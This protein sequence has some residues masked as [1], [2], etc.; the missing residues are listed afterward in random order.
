[1]SDKSDKQIERLEHL[2]EQ[3]IK[4]VASVTEQAALILSSATSTGHDH[5]TH[6][7]VVEYGVHEMF[8]HKSPEAA[9]KATA[10][11]L[12]GSENMF[13]GPGIVTINDKALTDALWSRLVERTLKALES[14]KAGKEHYALSGVLSEFGQKV[15]PKLRAELKKRVNAHAGKDVF[16]HDDGT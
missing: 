13:I 10:K 3:A 7:V 5:S 6:P 9:A 11:K 16:P 12:A 1:M 8:K 15:T 14:I 2:D 4:A